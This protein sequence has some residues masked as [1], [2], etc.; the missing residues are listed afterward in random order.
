MSRNIA[1][2]GLRMPEDMKKYLEDAAKANGRSLNAEVVFRLEKSI[3]QEE[4]EWGMANLERERSG[5]PPLDPALPLD[6]QMRAAQ[7]A[8]IESPN[9]LVKIKKPLPEQGAST[10]SDDWFADLNKKIEEILESLEE[11]KQ[12]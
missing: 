9:R 8:K 12:K 4:F 10:S 11:F 1:P 6:V 2:F 3:D 7:R 5:L